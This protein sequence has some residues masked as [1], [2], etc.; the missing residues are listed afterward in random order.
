MQGFEKVKMRQEKSTKIPEAL[1]LPCIIGCGEAQCSMIQQQQPVF[2]PDFLWRRINDSPYLYSVEFSATEQRT[3]CVCMIF[4][5]NECGWKRP[6]SV[7][8]QLRIF[9]FLK[10][11]IK[12]RKFPMLWNYQ[13]IRMAQVLSTDSPF[14]IFSKWLR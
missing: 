4:G 13:Y 1:E 3:G 12:V 9:F 2:Q 14:C 10:S 6:G 7:E 5:K 11:S 8:P